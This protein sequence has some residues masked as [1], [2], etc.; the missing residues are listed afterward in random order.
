MCT[1]KLR[2]FIAPTSS[3]TNLNHATLVMCTKCAWL[4]N[5]SQIS[6]QISQL[7]NECAQ[8]SCEHSL[9]LLLHPQ[10]STM[11]PWS[12]APSVRVPSCTAAYRISSHRRSTCTEIEGSTLGGT[13]WDTRHTKNTH[14]SPCNTYFDVCP[15]MVLF[16]VVMQCHL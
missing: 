12:C 5:A 4:N 13:L 16:P 3:S 8:S 6:I 15:S 1:V 14:L 11:Q 7:C 2:T 10:I 9:H